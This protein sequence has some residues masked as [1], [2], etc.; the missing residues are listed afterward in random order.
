MEKSKEEKIIHKFGSNSDVDGAEDIWEGGGDYTG[1]PTA[2]AE[3]FE[4]LSSSADDTSA[5]TGARTVRIWY[6]NDDYENVLMRQ[7]IILM[8]DVTLNGTAGVDSGVS[9]MRIWRAKVL[10]SGS[11]T[12]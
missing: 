5:G 3:N 1:F 9:G 8:V 12:N 10:T 11:G 7:E 2:A 6:Y 4:I